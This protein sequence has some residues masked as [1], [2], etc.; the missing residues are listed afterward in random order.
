MLHQLINWRR[1]LTVLHSRT[2]IR[3]RKSNC[4]VQCNKLWYNSRPVFGAA[5]WGNN[6]V[7]QKLPLSLATAVIWGGDR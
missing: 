6:M 3:G 5:G 2:D 1:R 4:D 7:G